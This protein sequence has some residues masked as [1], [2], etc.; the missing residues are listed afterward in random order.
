MLGIGVAIMI[1]HILF[2]V[3]GLILFFPSLE[4]HA[5]NLRGRLEKI[6]DTNT[7]RVCIWPDYYS[8]SYL[9]PKTHKLS[10]ID[11]DMAYAFGKDLGVK[12]QFV[13]TSFAKFVKD[14]NA[15]RCD[16]AM[17][18]VGITESRKKVLDFTR[19]HLASDIYAVVSKSN[20]RVKTW[21][22]IDKEG[23]VVAVAKGT[24][25]EP[26]M[27]AKLKHAKLIALQSSFAREQEVQSGR[28]DVF[29]TDYPYS[30]RFLAN[31]DWAR[32]IKPTS[33]YHMTHYGYAVKKG[34]AVWRDRVDQFVMDIKADG[35]LLEAAKH[36]GLEAIVIK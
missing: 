31:A 2:I 11:I 21:D 7:L 24:Y 4:A 29:M 17:F 6:L 33:I 5:D 22:D 34:D 28:A 13:D 27:Q 18:G 15:D 10:G 3:S 36:H 16:V 12:V 25:H 19:P 23:V 1:K 9:N 35:R 30:K 8:I 32:L 26:V 14:I 20:R